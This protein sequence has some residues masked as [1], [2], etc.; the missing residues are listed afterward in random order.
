[1]KSP[2]KYTWADNEQPLTP[3]QDTLLSLAIAV[4]AVLVMWGG[5]HVWKWF[6]RALLQ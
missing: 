2:V 4:G 6:V 5:W 1:M 3:L